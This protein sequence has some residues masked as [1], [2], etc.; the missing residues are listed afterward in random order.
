VK[1]APPTSGSVLDELRAVRQARRDLHE[2]RGTDDGA[3]IH[4][5]ADLIETLGRSA[6][7]VQAPKGMP[8]VPVA[9]RNAKHL[10]FRRSLLAVAADAL[11]AIESLDRRELAF[12][13]AEE[14]GAEAREAIG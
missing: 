1:L 3:P 6:E 5:L 2:L 8:R 14:A 13:H 4:W 10:A 11:L 7:L 9:E 12:Y